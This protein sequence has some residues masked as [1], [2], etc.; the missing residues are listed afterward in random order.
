MVNAS[1]VPMKNK[2]PTGPEEKK[3]TNTALKYTGIGFQML[4]IIA[5]GVF[6]GIK[7]DQYF[8]TPDIFTVVL[9]LISVVA[10]IYIAIKDFIKP[11]KK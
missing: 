7:A 10:A 9:S 1:W 3:P 6:A 2:V 11:K 8:K 5:I 4:A